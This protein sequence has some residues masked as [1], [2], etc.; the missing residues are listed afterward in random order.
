MGALVGGAAGAA[1]ALSSVWAPGPQPPTLKLLVAA[2]ASAAG[3]GLCLFLLAALTSP[4]LRWR[5]GRALAIGL[6]AALASAFFGTHL[7]SSVLKALSGSY[8]TLGAV[9]FF[10]AGGP[11]LL[12]TIALGY[13]RWLLLLV[14]VVG[15][16]AWLV[17]RHARRALRNHASRSPTVASL[18]L[19]AGVASAGLVPATLTPDLALASPEL[20]FVESMA[21]EAPEPLP[22]AERFRGRPGEQQLV[23]R[24]PP[25]G[26]LQTEGKRWADAVRAL[27]KTRTNVLLLTLESISVRHLGYLG[28]ERGTTPNLDRIAARSLRARRAWSTATH[29]NYAQMAILSSLFPRRTTGLDVY[30]RIDYPRVLLHDVFHTVGHSTATI[31]SQDETWQGMLKFQETGTPTF[32]RHSKNYSG[33]RLDIGSELVVLDHVT[34]DVANDWIQRQGARP[35]SM[36]V[37]FQATHFPYKLQAGI[38]APYQ[39]TRLTPGG[40]DYLSYPEGDRQA[41][42]NRYDNALRYVDEQIGKLERT[43]ERLGKLDDTIWVITADHGE[44]FHDHGQVTH[45][46][47]LYD[48]EARVPLLIHWPKGLTPA[49]VNEPVSHLDILPTILDLLKLPP[50]PAF[51]GKSMLE[52]PDPSREQAGIY[53]NIQG[54]KSAEAIV[55]WPWKLVQNRSEKTTQLFQLEQDPE[56]SDNRVERNPKLAAALKATLSAQV[57]AQL[58][59]HK[60]DR[61][62]PSERYAPRL[63]TCP[64]VPEVQRAAAPEPD[65]PEASPDDPPEKAPSEPAPERKN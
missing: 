28:Y 63:L 38:P 27:P 42:I 41:V 20:A 32:Y 51:Q 64:N 31:S 56:E 57:S 11:H 24:A 39:P 7:T 65:E 3:A 61:T 47:T 5:A 33:T 34:V 37:N 9:D 58:A 50:H 30:K 46:K 45:G 18:A 1:A 44:N 36:Y 12:R 40:F 60:S 53:M 55:C 29:S 4:L 54:L 21:P 48:T 62:S 15:A 26:P 6:Q 8:L 22:V 23:V 19:A 13:G 16:V 2:T 49:D 10:V 43:L 17:V 25:E 59:Y 14:L 52:P 35:W